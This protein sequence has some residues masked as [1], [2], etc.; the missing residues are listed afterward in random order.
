MIRHSLIVTSDDV[1]PI[2]MSHRV[3]RTSFRYRTL[4][5]RAVEKTDEGLRFG[6]LLVDFTSA[7]WLAIMHYDQV[8]G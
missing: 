7:E 8:A 5:C 2:E 3:E 1:T 6:S 4:P